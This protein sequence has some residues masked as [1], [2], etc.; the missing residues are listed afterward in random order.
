MGIYLLISQLPFYLHY[1]NT[2]KSLTLKSPNQGVKNKSKTK[3]KFGKRGGDKALKMIRVC[4][5]SA[6]ERKRNYQ[7]STKDLLS[8]STICISEESLAGKKKKKMV[9]ELKNNKR[10][11]K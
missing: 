6:A 3:K 9:S 8:R 4:R 5:M 1:Y 10:T 7:Q 11:F 2:N